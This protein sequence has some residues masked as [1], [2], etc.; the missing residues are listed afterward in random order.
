MQCPKLTSKTALSLRRSPPKSITPIQSP[1]PTTVS[2]CVPIHSA[3]LPRCRMRSDRQTDRQ[4]HSTLRCI[5]VHCR[6]VGKACRPLWCFTVHAVQLA[7]STPCSGVHHILS[8][9]NSGT[10]WKRCRK[11]TDHG[12]ASRRLWCVTVHY[13]ALQCIAE[14][15]QKPCGP[16]ECFQ[17]IAVHYDACGASSARCGKVHHTHGNAKILPTSPIIRLIYKSP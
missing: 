4:D 6:N 8:P 13:G 16:L 12:N 17:T 15:L 10:L 3:V 1:T 2:N 14:T 11:L 5:V 9:H 7:S